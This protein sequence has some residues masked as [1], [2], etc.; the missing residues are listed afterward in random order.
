V[1]KISISVGF[2]RAER[3]DSVGKT[4]CFGVPVGMDE[5]RCYES[6]S[7]LLDDLRDGDPCLILRES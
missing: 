6:C 7:G 5:I 4:T 2:S 3:R 1:N